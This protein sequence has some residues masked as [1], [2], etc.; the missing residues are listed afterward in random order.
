MVLSG[1]TLGGVSS[2][3]LGEHVPCGI[4]ECK[5]FACA[6]FKAKALPQLAQK[7]R[8]IHWLEA[9]PARCQASNKQPQASIST[10]YATNSGLCSGVVHNKA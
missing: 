5:G 2:H 3:H 4:C 7:V 10:L 1:P 8:C 9:D 6:C